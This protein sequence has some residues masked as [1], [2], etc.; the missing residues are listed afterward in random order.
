MAKKFSKPELSRMING[1]IVKNDAPI[2]EEKRRFDMVLLEKYPQYTRGT[3]Q[4][5]IKE[6]LASINGETILKANYLLSADEE[7]QCDA[8]KPTTNTLE[9]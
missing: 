3:I 6:G 4:K 5:F 2:E 7:E 1:D 9:H 8:H